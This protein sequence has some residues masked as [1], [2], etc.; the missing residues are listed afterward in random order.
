NHDGAAGLR[1]IVDRGG[2]GLVQ[3]PATAEVPTM[4]T[5]AIRRVPEARV[6]PLAGIAAH[7][8]SLRLPAATR[9]EEG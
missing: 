8:G 9:R 4:P 5:A 1:K 6:L 7:L 2:I 3:E